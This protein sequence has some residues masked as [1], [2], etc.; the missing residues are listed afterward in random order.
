MCF[1]CKM[2]K[3]VYLYPLEPFEINNNGVKYTIPPQQ[4]LWIA[5]PPLSFEGESKTIFKSFIRTNLEIEKVYL[6]SIS[7]SIEEINFMFKKELM[8][9]IPNISSEISAPE[10]LYHG[11]IGGSLFTT[12]EV[13]KEYDPS[14]SMS[15]FYSMFKNV[16]EIEYKLNIEYFFNNEYHETELVWKYK[17]IRKTSF[18]RW[19]AIMGI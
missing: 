5:F 8:L 6:K 7:V 17:S 13:L 10:Y 4:Q 1:S 19:D 16:N 14:V 11:N 15:N 12:E 3:V 18:A 2:N 9:Y